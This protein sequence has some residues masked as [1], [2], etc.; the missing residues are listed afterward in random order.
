MILLIVGT[1]VMNVYSIEELALRVLIA[2]GSFLVFF[3][4]YI[5]TQKKAISFSDVK[6][7]TFIALVLGFPYIIPSIVLTF[8]TGTI[9]GIMYVIVKHKSVKA[10]M[11]FSPFLILGALLA[12]IWG[13]PIIDLY[14]GLV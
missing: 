5:L 7:I 9:F 11:P 14:L 10:R 4:V 2:F 12:L 8:L 1:F 6:L 13:Q 3:I